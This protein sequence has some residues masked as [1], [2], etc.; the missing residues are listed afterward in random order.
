MSRDETRSS[1]GIET[2]F[3]KVELAYMY[4]ALKCAYE[5][6]GLDYGLTEEVV[7]QLRFKIGRLL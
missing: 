1:K 4:D 2:T 5:A 3:T 6:D 7:E